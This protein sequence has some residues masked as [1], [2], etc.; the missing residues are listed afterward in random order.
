[1]ATVK[2]LEVSKYYDKQQILDNVSLNIEQGEFVAVI[3]PSGCGKSTLLRLVAGLEVIS[4]GKILFDEKCVNDIAPSKRDIAMVFQNYA[5]YPHMTCFENMAYGLKIRGMPAK[6]IKQKVQEV[7]EMLQISTCLHRKPQALSGGQRQRVA[8]GRAI[9]RSPAVFLFDE[10]LSNLDTKLRNEM[11]YEIRK[12]HQRLATTS[13]YVTHDQTEAMTMAS[14]VVVLNQGK[15]EQIGS[16]QDLYQQP[17][18]LFVAGF[19]GHYPMNLIPARLN[20]GSNLI[21]SEL[22]F[23][24]QA[25]G[26][27]SRLASE[28]VIGIRPEHLRINTR[29][30]SPAIRVKI[31]YIDDLGADKLIHA[32]SLCGTTQFAIRASADQLIGDGLLDIELNI[33]KAN[34]F[35]SKT[36]LRMGGWHESTELCAAGY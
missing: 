9:V 35:D 16:P 28:V 29:A 36:G 3:G 13:I 26:S 2:L 11:R 12:I 6:S 4:S 17:Q 27:T 10:P 18:S 30:G 23:E 25:P 20:S 7:A 1:M 22:G 5:L 21:S 24:I 19:T 8:M 31:E 14:K 33:T 32:Q 34:L 15:I